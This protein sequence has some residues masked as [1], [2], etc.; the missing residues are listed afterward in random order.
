MKKEEFNKLVQAAREMDLLTYFETS[1]YQVKKEGREYYVKDI[2]DGH[3][4]CIMP[5]TN[6]WYDHYTGIWRTNNS[7][8]CLVHV[9]D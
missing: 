1:G 9:L 8:D 4:L 3:Q 6:Q 5:D 7:I 2:P